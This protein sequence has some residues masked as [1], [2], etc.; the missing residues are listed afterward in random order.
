MIDLH[1]YFEKHHLKPEEILYIYHKNRKTVICPDHGESLE[2]F[3]PVR[4]VLE[5]LPKDDFLNISKGVVVRRDR[6]VGISRDGVYTMS[7]GKTFQ[8][9]KRGLSEHRRLGK[10]LERYDSSVYSR[11]TMP[12]SLLE[13][14][15]L[16]DDMPIA[17]CIIELVFNEE[18]HGIDFIFRY[19]NAQM[20]VIEGVPVEEMINRSFYEVFRNG[21]KKW[22]VAY[23]DVALNGTQRTI[24]DFSPEIGKNLTIT[25]YQPETGFCAC[26][27]QT[28]EV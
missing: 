12:L 25:C 27:L 21:E 8:G 22:L 5:I 14:C 18:G 3:A 13:K 15:T 20:A 4:R 24:D 26:I 19:C 9:R 10:E 11:H 2:L 1:A 23:A 6:I 17:Y 16:L 7:D 28:T